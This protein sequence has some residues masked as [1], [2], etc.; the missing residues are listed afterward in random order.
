MKKIH[1]FYHKI[2]LLILVLI[3]STFFS[4]TRS[5]ELEWHQ[6]EGYRWAEVSDGFFGGT[7]FKSLSSSETGI[8]FVN[9]ITEDEIAE[10]RHY[11][12][13]SGVAAGDIDGDGLVDLYFAGLNS[14]NK[15][16]KNLGGM[17]FEDI[18]DQAGV[19]H[20]GF[21]S[22]GVVFSDVNGN[23]HL[24]LLVT[25]MHGENTL[26]LND[27]NG[28]YTRA[29]NSG[30]GI[31]QG[32]NTMALADISG[33]GYPDLYITR[34]KEQSVKDVYTTEELD[35]SN[36]LAEPLR[37]PTDHYTLIP[38][39]DEHYELVRQEGALTGISEIGRVDELYFNNGGRFEKIS[40][41][42]STFLDADGQPFGLQ[43]DWGLTAK[44]QDLNNDGLQDLYVCNDFHTPDR[45][46]FN[47]GDS[48][49]RAMGWQAVRNLSYSCMAVDFS[50]VN[51]DGRQDIF[52]TEMLD[53]EHHRR[54]SQVGSL[55]H[56]S[57]PVGD[58]ES[59]P[60]YNRNSMYLQREDGTFTETSRLSALGATGWSWATRFMDIDLDGYEDL[61]VATG[62]LYNILDIDAQFSMVRN[63]R[64]MDEHFMEFLNL[65]EPLN[66]Q[67]RLLKNNGVSAGET[68][69]VFSDVSSDW[70]FSDFDVSQGMALSD[71]NNDGALDVII[72]R[73]NAVA[74]IY[75]NRTTAPRIAVRLK[76][77]SPNTQ[78]I[79]AKI[80]FTGGPVQQTKEISVGGDY[81]SGSDP[82]VMFAADSDNPAHTIHITWP[83]GSVSLIDSVKANRM[84]EIDQGAIK[85][86][87][88][89]TETVHSVDSSASLFE[90]IS[91]QLGHFHHEDSFSD[92]EIQP[93]L[94]MKLSQQ[95]PGV[96][97][98]DITGDGNDDLLISSGKG[99]RL[100]VFQKKGNEQLQET[101]IEGLT[102]ITP[103]DQTCL[104][105]TSP[106][107][108]DGL[109]SR[110]PSSA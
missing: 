34:Y 38:P 9:Q 45:I 70:G 17:K 60:L 29:E 110:M 90:D 72:N 37:Q 67:N 102:D 16:Y 59:R 91:D 49:F 19:A 5:T 47:Q 7:G 84:Y 74:A 54:L 103:G 24:D 58:I 15:L 61:I 62:Y 36:I 79:G 82:L 64:N 88:I 71:L 69:P 26:Y 23:G 95:G 66:L 21:Y 44:F 109:L 98:L 53:T 22:T 43:P 65:V 68:A 14:S 13:G 4:C 25:A 76:G 97:W 1:V 39:F 11:L 99:G 101:E 92:F 30:L 107:P 81:A 56:V 35:W 87:D 93:L 100:A 63:R 46:W 106:S 28:N 73:M 32:S 85:L 48:T 33:N 2:V 31:A 50:D 27:G 18:T 51:R 40:D 42:E 78:A 52:T 6:E 12:N 20:E 104:L 89:P 83:D 94:P 86:Q 8:N 96:A 57:I 10:N 77:K 55:D 108:R 75:E 41:T 3:W 105:Y 80:E